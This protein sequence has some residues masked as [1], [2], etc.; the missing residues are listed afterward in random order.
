MQRA[1]LCL[2]LDAVGAA[3]LPELVARAGFS[4][5]L[6]GSRRLAAASS[7]FVRQIIPADTNGP[8]VREAVEKH[9]AE[10]EETYSFLLSDEPFLRTFLD[11]A[12]SPATARLLPVTADPQG[13]A[14]L[15]SKVDFTVDAEVAGVPVPRFRILPDGRDLERERWTGVPFVVKS[16][17]SLA[18]SGVRLVR[19]ESDLLSAKQAGFTG[20]LIVQE[21]VQGR[22]GATAVLYRRGVPQC[23]YSYW[24]LRNWPNPLAAASAFELFWDPQIEPFI[25]KLGALSGFDGLCGV[26]WMWN[27][28][29]NRIQLIEMNIRPTPGLYL[30]RHA[31]VSFDKALAAWAAGRELIQ[32][33]VQTSGQV[34]RLWPQNL[35]PAVEGGEPMEFIRAF[36]SAPWSDPGLMVSQFR[37][38]VTHFLPTGLRSALRRTLRGPS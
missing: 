1:L 36:S 5:D 18:G 38:V 8:S 19:S 31:G 34:L 35:Y 28:E 3:R 15:L 26:D 11:R 9:L 6:V 10:S 24:L 16:A 17:E 27:S 14:R 2:S 12:A 4:T 25:T 7:G 33:P 30:G 37:R 21:Y 23:W 22:L 29:L 20:P 13:F 32:R